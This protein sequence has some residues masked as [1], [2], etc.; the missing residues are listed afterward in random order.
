MLR[1]IVAFLKSTGWNVLSI[2]IS[3]LQLIVLF[4]YSIFNHFYPNWNKLLID[5]VLLF[6]CSSFI[7][8]TVFEYYTEKKRLPKAFEG[9]FFVAIPLLMLLLIA[10]VYCGSIASLNPDINLLIQVNILI[11]IISIIYSIIYRTIKFYSRRI[12]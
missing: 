2:L 9:I 7:V 3:L 10:T 12:K 11:V 8:S 6:F 1:V 4:I 5:G